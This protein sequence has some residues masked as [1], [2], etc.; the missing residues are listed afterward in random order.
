MSNA[1][2][3]KYS[4]G[5]GVD[6]AALIAGLGLGLTVAMQV[7]TMTFTDISSVYALITSFSRLCALVGTY[8]AISGIFLIARIPFVERGV[9]HDRLVT[10]H[11]KLAP[12]SL[13][14]IGFHVF[15]II[16]GFAGQDQIP[17][18]KELW[19]ML[20]KFYW[21]WAALGGFIL[22]ILA[23][24]TS[25]KKAR[26]K[27]S[28]ETWWIIHIYTYAAVALSFMHQVLNGSMFVGHPLNRWFWTALYV[29]MG[30]SVL[31]WRIGLP[32][33]R[34]MR[35]NIKVDR[36]VIEGPGVVSVIMRG[37]KLHKLAAQGGQFFSWRFLT[38]GHLLVAHPYSLSAAPTEHYV[39]ITVKDLGD[40]SRSLALLR[41]GTRVFVEGPY[42]AFTAGRASSPHVVLVGGGVGITPIRAI[43]EEFKNGVQMDVI[44]RASKE[45]DLVLRE[46][47]DYLA[48]N[49]DGTIRVHYLLGPRK[50]HPMDARALTKLVPSFADADVYICGPTPLV[51]SVRKAAQD[52]GVPK[53]KFH[54][55]AFAYHKEIK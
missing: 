12:Y 51:E 35:H 50:N 20:T 31:Y 15:F 1:S 27:M 24:V 29:V 42:G 21:M 19:N 10:W 43:I 37:R 45:E 46:E 7:T 13:F 53:D 6:W 3:I 34:S 28:Y 9:G 40:H 38:Q 39:R 55:E 17:L 25:Y 16:F 22:M 5:A 33:V 36:V 8:F 26:A 54:D 49:S 32:L 47:L 11:R 18:Y 2:T 14:L 30:A 41:P 23:G 44:F 52:V 48:A 4:S